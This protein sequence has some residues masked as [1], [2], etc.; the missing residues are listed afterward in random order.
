[1]LAV[2]VLGLIFTATTVSLRGKWRAEQARRG[3]QCVAVTWRKARSLAWREGREWVVTWDPGHAQLQAMPLAMAEQWEETTDDDAEAA[4]EAPA[5]TVDLGRDL[6]LVCDPS[7]EELASVHFLPNGRVPHAS[8]R[9]ADPHGTV[10]RV[11]TDWTGAPVMEAAKAV[12]NSGG[13]K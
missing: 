13:G 2:S 9:V 7:G 5:F 3:A 12:E 10:W 8:V 11:R 1:M 6:R 4:D